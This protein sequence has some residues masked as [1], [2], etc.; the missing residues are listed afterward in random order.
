MCEEVG[1][2]EEVCVREGVCMRK[3]GCVRRCVCVREGTEVGGESQ[4][5]LMDWPWIIEIIIV[6]SNPQTLDL[7]PQT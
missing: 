2:C 4:W 5:K 1:V 3:W 7:P 6:W